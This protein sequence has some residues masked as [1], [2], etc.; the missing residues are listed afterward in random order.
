[1][2]PIPYPGITIPLLFTIL[3]VSG[4]QA[5]SAV[6]SAGGDATGTGGSVAYSVGQVAYTHIDGEEGSISL[7]VQQPHFVI[8][9]DTDHPG[10]QISAKAYPN[11]SN[12]FVMLSLE[13]GENRI[14]ENLSFSIFSVDGANLFQQDITSTVTQVSLEKFPA[15]TYLIRITR[16]NT[17]IKTFK[18]FKTN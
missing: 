5:Q 18:I 8:M 3:F 7:G 4:I 10:L 11:P 12:D 6:L 15:A 2:R 17:L 13:N 16:D 9:V 1:M 14:D